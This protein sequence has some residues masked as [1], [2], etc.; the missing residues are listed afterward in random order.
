MAITNTLSNLGNLSG[1][2]GGAPADYKVSNLY[3]QAYTDAIRLQIQ[4]YD[5]LLSDT[6]EKETIE[7]EVK[8]FDKL[9]KKSGTDILVERTRMGVYGLAGATTSSAADTAD[10]D[11]GASDT[12]RRM[13]EP[14]WFE[15]AELFDPRDETGLM[16]SIRPDSQYMRNLAAIFNQKKD[17]IILEA[18]TGNVLVQQRTGQGVTVNKT[19]G[20]GQTGTASGMDMAGSTD[21]VGTGYSISVDSGTSVR[22]FT[23]HPGLEGHEIGCKLARKYSD[24][25]SGGTAVVSAGDNADKT[26][27]VAFHSGFTDGEDNVVALAGT[28]QDSLA[29]DTTDTTLSTTGVT[30]FNIEKL[31]RA[32]QKL[33]T[34]HAL[35]AGGRYICVLHPDQFYSLM[36]DASDTRFNSIDFNDG[37]PLVNGEAFRFMGFEFRM[38]TL[39]PQATVTLAES[40]TTTAGEDWNGTEVTYPLEQGGS[41]IRYAY[42]YTPQCGIFG[43]NANMEVRFD[44]I[45]ERG[46]ALQMWHQM[47]MNAIRMDGDCIVR[48]AS[49]DEP[50]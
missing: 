5:S 44:E 27:L 3:K 43:T 32:R 4:Q 38:S 9:L 24:L 50:A 41:P 15:Y 19:M 39:I 48:V 18:L 49:V 13:I 20:Y 11:Y 1:T 14:K 31:I 45:P 46:Y 7:G 30:P 23:A 28:V 2:G 10:A 16:K 8:S 6:L 37:K 25:N 42:F 40:S 12:E 34:L 26:P 33:D 17:K 36:A 29:S 22:T 35:R 21:T 47:G